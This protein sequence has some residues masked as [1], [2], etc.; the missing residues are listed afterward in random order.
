MSQLFSYSIYMSS[1]LDVSKPIDIPTYKKNG[2]AV[3]NNLFDPFQKSPPNVFMNNL[4]YR[5][6]KFE[7]VSR[8]HNNTET[9]IT[10]TNINNTKMTKTQYKNN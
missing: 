9:N 10:D 5:I 7:D 3:S 1:M 4:K 6:S 2:Y 8:I